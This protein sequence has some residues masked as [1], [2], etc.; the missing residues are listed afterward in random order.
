MKL[1]AIFSFEG[2]IGETRSIRNISGGDNE[3]VT[4][5]PIPNTA[6]KLFDAD[7]SWLETACEN[8]KPP[9]LFEGSVQKA[10]GLLFVAAE[11]AFRA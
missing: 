1:V 5:V 2:T 10:Q 4:P 11:V 8:M 9:D 7:D 6:V 3:E